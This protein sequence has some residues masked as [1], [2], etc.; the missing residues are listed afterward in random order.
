MYFRTFV[1]AIVALCLVCQV[2]S[3][4][5]SLYINKLIAG[6]QYFQSWANVVELTKETFSQ[7]VDGSTN[8]LVEFYAPWCGHCK[9]LAPEYKLAAETFQA[10]E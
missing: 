6:Q 7:H 3:S 2:I 8:V 1:A 10:G 9:N 4:P 5:F